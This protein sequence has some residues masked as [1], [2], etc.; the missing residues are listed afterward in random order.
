MLYRS[1]QSTAYHACSNSSYTV[2]YF[3]KKAGRQQNLEWL[4]NDLE[5]K[6]LGFAVVIK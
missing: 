5:F 1:L 4:K 6:H 2:S 3:L